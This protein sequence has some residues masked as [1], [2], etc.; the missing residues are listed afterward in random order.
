M[1]SYKDFAYFYDKLMEDV[2]YKKWFEYVLMI[3][4]RLEVTPKKVLEIACGT[5]NFTKYLCDNGYDVTCFD[6][7]E[8]M[9]SVAYD[10]L[11]IYRNVIILKQDMRLFNINKKFDM[12]ISVCDGINYITAYEDLVNVFKRVKL[13]LEEDGVFIFDISSYYKLHE[14]IGNNTFV[15]E[16]DNIF[17]VWEN[18]FDEHDNICELYITFFVKQGSKYIRFDENHIQKAYSIDEIVNALRRAGF[19]NI[20]YYE[21]FTFNK[22]NDKSERMHFI[23]RK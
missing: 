22:P 8:D 14:I 15:E 11:N 3:L 16:N 10:K 9:L 1:H 7:S 6:L 19:K 12:V 4:K 5:G 2:D 18:Y 17:Y 13:H 23:V 21:S 20:D